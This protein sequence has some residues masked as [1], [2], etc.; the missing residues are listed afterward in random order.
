MVER[1]SIELTDALRIIARPLC[2]ASSA[3]ERREVETSEYEEAALRSRGRSE[4]CNRVVYV[5][6]V[7]GDR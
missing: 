1:T 7:V 4:R 6:L 3:S 2:I 5:L